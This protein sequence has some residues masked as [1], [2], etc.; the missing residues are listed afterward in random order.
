MSDSETRTTSRRKDEECVHTAAARGGNEPSEY[1][2]TC[3]EQKIEVGEDAR[4]Q[5]SSVTIIERAV[6]GK[7]T[8]KRI[9]QP[10]DSRHQLTQPIQ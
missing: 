9:A 7:D 3:F 1:Y 2:S 10:E 4:L 5:C 8:D 6:S